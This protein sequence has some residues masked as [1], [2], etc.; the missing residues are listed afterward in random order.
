[1]GQGVRHAA[2][3][4]YDVQPLVLRLQVLVQLNLHIVEL[5]LHT[6]EQGIVVRGTRCDLVQ[7]IYHLY[8]AV[9]YP[10]WQHEAQIT[11]SGCESR[12]HRPLLYP[13]PV[14]PAP[15]LQ[16][17]EALHYGSSSQHVGEPCYPLTVAVAVLE[18][19]REMLR[20]Q[21]CEVGILR[22]LGL[23]LEAVPVHGHY[24]VGI[25]IHHDTSGVHAE[26][27]H[28]VLELVGAVHDL[29]LVELIGDVREDHC[30]ELH[31]DTYVH[32]V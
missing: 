25:L 32:T 14:A 29:S 12:P 23:I 31:S 2:A 5:H 13:L 21:Q 10:L 3:V 26:G 30:R 16:I 19:L 9:Q 18:G 8:D 4:S 24:P 17:A 1:M 22:L 15:S 20:H 6:V 27:A 11:W 7:R 28:L